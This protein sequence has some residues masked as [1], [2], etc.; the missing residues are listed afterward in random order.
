LIIDCEANAGIDERMEKNLPEFL[1]KYRELQPKIPVVLVSRV[2][3]AM[4]FYDS[5]RIKLRKYYKKFLIELTKKY[6]NTFFL[7]GSKILKNNFTEYT[8]DGIHPT[9][10]G[11]MLIAQ[12]Y[13]K[14]INK[15]SGEL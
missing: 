5:R 13:L 9:D 2:L 1:D 14:I 15:I 12:A 8:V 10:G 6:E 7:D 11:N 3:F 4:D